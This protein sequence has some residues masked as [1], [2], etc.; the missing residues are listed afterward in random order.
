M[1][2]LAMEKRDSLC[3]WTWSTANQMSGQMCSHNYFG[4]RSAQND[5]YVCDT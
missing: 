4:N 3:Y 5:K 2:V 1:T